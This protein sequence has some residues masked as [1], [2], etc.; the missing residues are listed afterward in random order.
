MT[1]EG[2]VKGKVRKL[3]ARYNGLYTYWPVPTGFGKTT[4]DCLGCYRGQF[5]VVETK[6]AGKKPTLLQTEELKSI[7]ASMGKTFVISGE[8]SPVLEELRAWLD[9]IKATI[10][11]NF[12][13]PS[14]QVRRAQI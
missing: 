1:P 13:I 12:D 7:A 9:H 4:L 5:F 6:A 8:D 10:D 14:D 3:L 2:R 11:D